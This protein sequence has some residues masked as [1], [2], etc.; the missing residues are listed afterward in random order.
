MRRSARF[1]AAS[2]LALVVAGCDGAKAVMACRTAAQC[3]DE[4]RRHYDQPAREW[5]QANSAASRRLAIKLL[6]SSN[7]QDRDLGAW[8]VNVADLDDDPAIHRVVA[9]SLERGPEAARLHRTPQDLLPSLDHTLRLVDRSPPRNYAYA[10]LAGRFG[11]RAVSAVEQRLRCRP[12][13]A[14]LDPMQASAILSSVRVR[15]MRSPSTQ[16]GSA[17][18]GQ[19]VVVPI[20]QLI[21]DER[22]SDTARLEA[23]LLMSYQL[24][25]HG[26]YMM[27]PSTAAMLK[28]L[29]Q[30]GTAS[31]R[32]DAIRVA[33][34]LAAP[35]N[36][37]DWQLITSEM[38]AQRVSLETLP[39]HL[40]STFPESGPLH[41]LLLRRLSGEDSRE[42]SLALHLLSDFGSR[43][44][45]E[46]AS[47]QAL[48]SSPDPSLATQAALTLRR[49]G[50]LSA[51]IDRAM[52]SHWFPAARVMSDAGI[53]S[54]DRY[55]AV[56]NST[57]RTKPQRLSAVIVES[58]QNH[59]LL[60]RASQRLQTDISHAVEYDDTIVASFFHGEFGGYLAVL[61]NGQPPEIIGH[62][63]FGPLLHLGGNRFLVTSGV[64]H[65]SSL[66]GDVYELQV[67][68][69][70]STLTHRL[71][72]L[73]QPLAIERRRGRVLL[74]TYAFG[75]MDLTDP[76]APRW[77]GCQR[78]PDT[79][80]WP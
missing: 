26:D 55:R 62:E 34:S 73:S 37:T 32:R 59:R 56:R 40:S 60:R 12:A 20:A 39:L 52:A 58:T 19:E 23:G 54:R 36:T 41:D 48:L 47:I 16:G 64:A 69:V 71:G 79:P 43:Y 8:L 46:R 77:L 17:P 75:V 63:P 9:A 38:D 29:L 22:E 4:W 6:L 80:M 13:C 45:K 31:E 10:G 25:R 15:A 66:A 33:V 51:E 67:G 70:S 57:C 1:F 18:D 42:A 27:T 53:S 5:L 28:K 21:D 14:R 72:D 24:W 30:H 74:S 78:P 49:A 11:L 76:S 61:R 2:L 65:M 35:P 7:Y 50:M 3:L 44:L 68:P